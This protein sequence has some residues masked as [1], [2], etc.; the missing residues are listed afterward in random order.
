MYVFFKKGLSDARMQEL[1]GVS[2]FCSAPFGTE[3][4]ELQTYGERN[5]HFT[6]TSAGLPQFTALGTKEA[7]PPTYYFLGGH[8]DAITEGFLPNYVQG[9]HDWETEASQHL[10]N[11]PFQG[12]RIERPSNFSSIATPTDDK[13]QDI[14]RG[15]RPVSDLKQVV[16]EWRDG[17][18]E[19]GRTF[20]TNVMKQYGR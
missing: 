3:E 17:G 1:L 10:E 12:I 9:L 18:G 4:F 5:K 14:L 16:Q 8:N 19:E 6:F 7:S 15:K 11:H 2:N 13:V 20:Y